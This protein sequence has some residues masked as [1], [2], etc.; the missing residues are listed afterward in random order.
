MN[1]MEV[2]ES[3]E[4]QAQ[5][6]KLELR[7]IK[8]RQHAKLSSDINACVATAAVW[9]SIAAVC[10]CLGGPTESPMIAG[11]MTTLLIWSMRKME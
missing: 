2:Q 5:E 1:D 11:T 4:S 6:V 8:F 9:L 3:Q 7:R 10:I